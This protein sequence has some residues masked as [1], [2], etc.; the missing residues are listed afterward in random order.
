M[1]NNSYTKFYMDTVK[2][3]ASVGL[4]SLIKPPEKYVPMP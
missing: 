3:T 4:T 2:N 1:T